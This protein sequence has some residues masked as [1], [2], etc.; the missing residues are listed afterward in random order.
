MRKNILAGTICLVVCLGMYRWGGIELSSGK[1][2]VLEVMYTE[3]KQLVFPSIYLY[4]T[5][6]QELLLQD[7]KRLMMPSIVSFGTSANLLAEKQENVLQEGEDTKAPQNSTQEGEDAKAP[8]NSTQGGEDAKAPQ[9]STQEGEDAKTPQN[10]TQGGEDAKEPQN[11]TQVA[12]NTQANESATETSIYP[13][14]EKQKNI[15]RKKLQDFDYLR[16]NFYQVDNTT[17][18]DSTLLNAK[19]FLKKDMKLQKDVEGPQILIYHTHSKEAFS[20]SK[21]G[22]T[23]VALG[24]YLEEILE[25][26]YGIEVLHHKGKY[27]TPTRDNAYAQAQPNIEKILKE[28]PSIEVVIDLHRDGVPETTHLVTEINGKP[29]AQIMFFNG[30]CRT[31]SGELGSYPNEYLEDNLAC[32]FQM[33]LTAMEYY[34]G[35]ARRIYLKGYRYNMHLCPKSMLIEVGAQNNTFAEAKNAMEPLADILSKVLLD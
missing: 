31:T 12:E 4:N 21:K 20:D 27:D 9:K 33:H 32:S 6:N 19:K 26:R 16:Q 2:A 15:N 35:F 8:Q 24:D 25:T 23:V 22:E 28:N 34:P 1:T 10:S 13:A 14:V 18:V 29:T 5:S 3:I 7:A 30:L 11:S 17:T